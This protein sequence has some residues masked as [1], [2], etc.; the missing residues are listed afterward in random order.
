VTWTR[1]GGGLF[2]WVRLPE[3]VDAARLLDRAVEEAGI[4]FVPGA[5]FF[6]DGRGR[7]TLRL[8]YSLPSEAEIEDGIARLARLI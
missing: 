1:P 2:V 4:A 3:A 6:H 5:A 7:N 8:S